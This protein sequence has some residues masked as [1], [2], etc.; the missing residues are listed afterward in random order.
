MSGLMGVELWVLSRGHQAGC[1][2]QQG[3]MQQ[4][5]VSPMSTRMRPAAVALARVS[6]PLEPGRPALAVMTLQ[7]MRWVGWWG[8]FAM[9]G[10]DL[11]CNRCVD[12]RVGDRHNIV[13]GMRA[14]G[15]EGCEC[16]ADV[17]GGAARQWSRQAG[18]TH[19]SHMGTRMAVGIAT[20]AIT[21]A[22]QL[23]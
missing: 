12:P 21:A 22:F 6:L 9:D 5:E 8:W 17:C 3:S 10:A 16:H 20:Q 7:G 19:R 15:C 4:R 1:A 11:C 14:G 2:A 18:S 13:G 23:R